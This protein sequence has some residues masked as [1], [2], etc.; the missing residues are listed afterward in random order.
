MNDLKTSLRDLA[1]N[2]PVASARP[3]ADL[4]ARG[5]KARRTERA[6]RLA[7][8]L[9]VVALLVTLGAVARPLGDPLPADQ[10][11]VPRGGALPAV[12]HAPTYPA[13]DWMPGA[14]FDEKKLVTD[15]AVGRVSVAVSRGR[16]APLLVR[17]DDGKHLLVQLP[18]TDAFNPNE[19]SFLALRPDGRA[20]AYPWWRRGETTA[21][22][23]AGV[24]V[25][26]LL[27]GEVEQYT[28][29]GRND[30]PVSVQ[31]ISW[32]PDGTR[33]AWL[34]DE[35]VQWDEGG[36]SFRGQVQS[37]GT[38]GADGEPVT[39][40]LPGHP[41]SSAVAATSTGLVQ[42]LSQRRLW[43]LV[44]GREAAGRRVAEAR[45]S[46]TTAVV[47]RDGTLLTAGRADPGTVLA[48]LALDDPTARLRRAPWNSTA[49]GLIDAT[50]VPLGQSAMDTFV[51]AV[52]PS[53][54]AGAD[55]SGHLETRSADGRTRSDL[56]L[57]EGAPTTISVATQ[58]A[59][60]PSVA[61]PAPDWPYSDE[62]KVVLVL[63][64]LGVV[65]A[66]AWLVRPLVRRR[67]ERR[68]ALLP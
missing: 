48:T 67:R 45:Q 40:D 28:L 36:T 68:A 20:L 46:W 23:E 13:R 64:A 31:K 43:T 50:V 47:S 24:G 55:A 12:V 42:V 10:P 56:T 2:T 19:G 17:A 4:W 33:L 27:T 49:N 8:A 44:E 63:L 21:E 37:A 18:D 1:E 59:D 30:R 22:T 7:A 26:D 29:R 58:L 34:G 60:V 54:L 3:A 6:A 25:V 38:L 15:L 39:W 53:A 61:F 35:A 66:V 9:A 41:E 65:V 11:T 5:R 57:F 16:N 14:Q 52:L 51:V 62:R 32:S